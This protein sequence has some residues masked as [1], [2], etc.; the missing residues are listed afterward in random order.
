[1]RPEERIDNFLKILGEQWKKQGTD[2]RFFQ[3]LYNNGL[4]DDKSY[5]MEE[6]DIIKVFPDVPIRDYL[7]WGTYGKKGNEPL[8]YIL[9]KDMTDEHITK[10]IITQHLSPIYL[11]YFINELHF[12]IEYP[13]YSIE[14]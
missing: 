7:L 4:C 12:R 13:E 6:H 11:Q 1:M 8:R 5:H 2:L 3:F 14:G 9:L 10:V